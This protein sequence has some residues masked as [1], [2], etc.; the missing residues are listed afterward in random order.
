MK[1]NLDI[2][3]NKRLRDKINE[4]GH[5]S[6]N[7]TSQF[8]IPSDKKGMQREENA[9]NCI[10]AALDRIDD[11]VEHCN[12]LDLT[13]TKEGTFALCDL[14]NYGQT[15]IDCITIIG[16]IYGAR[17]NSSNDIS[18]FGQ[19]GNSGSGNDEKYF[20]YLRSLCS[21][22]PLAT[23]AHSEYQGDQPE[24]CPYINTGNSTAGR[25][26]CC[27]YETLGEIDFIVNVYRNDR[28]FSKYIPIYTKQLFHYI[29]KR[30][31]FINIIVRSV[32]EYNDS[33]IK[34]LKEKHILLPCEYASYDEYLR[35]LETE[36]DMRFGREEFQARKWRAIFKTHYEDEQNEKFL[37]MYQEEL[38]NGI[39][40]IHVQ[41][42]SMD[43][44]AENWSCDA[45][46][47]CNNEISKEYHYETEKLEYLFPSYAIENRANEDFSFI[48]DPSTIDR[49]R[50]N[51]MLITIEVARK[52]GAT[53][54]DLKNVARQ[55]DLCYSTN[56]SEWAR[57]QL[58]IME[59]AFSKC[60][61]FDYYSNDW[62]L[63][64]QTKMAEWLL[65]QTKEF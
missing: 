33:K 60:L 51:E 44:L 16:N 19:Q 3:L 28:T 49:A 9:F 41:L 10:C 17:Y 5:F 29:N 24:W 59:P 64:L 63:Y 27:Q 11:L 2:Q 30:Y 35:N 42:Q 58:K 62:H 4:Y 8:Q 18:S 38:K 20:K 12:G 48:D 56:N 34:Q 7:K 45:I 26:L 25:L 46:D 13:Q 65:R 55:L 57:I 14:F 15:L 52:N 23:H 31:N 47:D 21:V 53:H 54:S 6:F 37:S 32:D 40:K 22:H 43:C 36:I 1:I 61:T 39:A 50:L